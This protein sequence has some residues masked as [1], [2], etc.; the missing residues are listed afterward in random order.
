MLFPEVQKDVNPGTTGI[1]TIVDEHLPRKR[2]RQRNKGGGARSAPQREPEEA[3]GTHEGRNENSSGS[4]RNWGRV[5][6]PMI[7]VIQ[8]LISGY[9]PLK[10]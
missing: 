6:N 3:K 1:E 4:L 2:V 7:T 8:A 9:G 5:A 10:W